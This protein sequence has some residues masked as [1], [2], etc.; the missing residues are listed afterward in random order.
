MII[1]GIHILPNTEIAVLRKNARCVLFFVGVSEDQINS[2][3]EKRSHST[4]MRK[5]RN[6]FASLYDRISLHERTLQLA[7]E[8]DLSI[9]QGN[10]WCAI[11]DSATRVVAKRLECPAL[12][13]A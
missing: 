8:N 1:E 10:D 5:V 3:F 2:N 7:R 11:V 12:A 13:V 9:V 6:G 4:H